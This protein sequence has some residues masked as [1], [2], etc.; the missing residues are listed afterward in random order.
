MRLLQIRCILVEGDSDVQKVCSLYFDI[1]Y[2]TNN[3][4][5]MGG[6]TP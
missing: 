1:S 6:M 3:V 5:S 4:K 2:A